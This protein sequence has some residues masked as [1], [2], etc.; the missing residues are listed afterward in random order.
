MGLDIGERRAYVRLLA[1]V[2]AEQKSDMER[3]RVQAR[4]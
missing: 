4:R 3:A 1:D 2:L